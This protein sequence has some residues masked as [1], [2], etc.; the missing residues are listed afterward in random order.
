MQNIV[1]V[2][3][4]V[5]SVGRLGPV[6]ALYADDDSFGQSWLILLLPVIGTVYYKSNRGFGWRRA[7]FFGGISSVVMNIPGCSRNDSAQ[8]SWLKH[9]GIRYFEGSLYLYKAK[10]MDDEHLQGNHILHCGQ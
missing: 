5:D 3:F 6:I 1:S 10:R 4:V 2:V 8:H 9:H 7:I